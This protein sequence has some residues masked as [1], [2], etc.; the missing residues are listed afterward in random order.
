[1]FQMDFHCGNEQENL[2][3]KS[4]D[5]LARQLKIATTPTP[6]PAAAAHA[7]RF[8]TIAVD[9]DTAFMSNLFSNNT[10]NATNW[11]AKMINTMNLTY[12]RDLLV[13]LYL[14]TTIL[15]TNPATDPYKAGGTNPTTDVPADGTD[16]DNFG[17]Y[18]AA[19]EAGVTRAFAVLLS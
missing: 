18:W 19:N 16:L 7:L 15:R 4:A 1:N 6:A 14:G 11:I 17:N 13:R 9:T 5:D 8:A 12:E 10:T 2:H 3:A